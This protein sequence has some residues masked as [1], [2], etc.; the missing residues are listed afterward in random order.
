MCINVSMLNVFRI[1]SLAELDVAAEN[2]TALP[3]VE[4]LKQRID[5]FEVTNRCV[6]LQQ[7]NVV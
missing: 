4:G 7:R 2:L 3:T 1:D 5:A 6:H